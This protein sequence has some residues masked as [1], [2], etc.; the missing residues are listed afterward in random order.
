MEKRLQ[1]LLD[2]DRYRRVCEESVRSGRSVA[3]VIREAID[4]RFPDDGSEA[5]RRAAGTLLEL[6]ATP[7]PEPP[8]TPEQLKAAYG[9]MLDLKFG[10]DAD[11][12]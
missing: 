12:S 6:S 3:A 1:L 9:E 8:E 7:S 4:L 11:L 10:A 2:A 5:R